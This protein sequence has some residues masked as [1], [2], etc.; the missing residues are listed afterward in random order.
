MNVGGTS[1]RRGNNPANDS[2][3]LGSNLDTAK[4]FCMNLKRCAPR[5]CCLESESN[6]KEKLTYFVFLELFSLIRYWINNSYKI[7]TLT[8]HN[9]KLI[10]KYSLL[11]KYLFYCT[12]PECYHPHEHK[13]FVRRIRLDVQRKVA[14]FEGTGW[15]ISF[16]WTFNK[17]GLRL[18]GN[19]P[20]EEEAENWEVDVDAETVTTTTTP[21][22][23]GSHKLEKRYVG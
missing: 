22:R 19:V 8:T 20:R 3:V 7:L 2:A 15:S 5:R 21:F 16:G 6:P 9:E 12:S 1:K 14:H 17:K 4:K 23:A 13:V 18:N 11:M 10:L